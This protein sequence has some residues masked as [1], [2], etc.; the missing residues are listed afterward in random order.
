VCLL[1]GC[2]PLL[3]LCASAQGITKG[4]VQLAARLNE[5]TLTTET[6]VEGELVTLEVV[7]SGGNLFATLEVNTAERVQ[8]IMATKLF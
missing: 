2:Q 4:E 1:L 7:V 3:C 5:R 8:G 6:Y